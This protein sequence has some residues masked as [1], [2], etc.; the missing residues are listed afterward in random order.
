MS[1]SPAIIQRLHNLYFSENKPKK[2]TPT[3]VALVTYLLLRQSEDHFIRDTQETLGARLGC[4]RRTIA[5][6]IKRLKELGWLIVE[7]PWEF[8]PTNHRKTRTMYAPLGLSVNLD[9]LPIDRARRSAPGEE[10]KDLA[11]KHSGVLLRRGVGNRYKRSPKRWK[12]HQEAAAQRLIDETGS[13]IA[14][15]NV[16]NFALK[17]PD[18]KKAAHTSL[19]HI[20]RRLGRIQADMEAAAASKAAAAESAD[21]VGAEG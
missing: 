1:T 12:S 17:H 19:Y 16:V 7:Q 11:M 18:H 6:S 10:A 20:R 4:D 13:K 15:V 14:A 5:R 8:N 2:I 3:D 9:K 21:P